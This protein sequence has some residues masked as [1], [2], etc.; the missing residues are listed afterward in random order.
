MNLEKAIEK[1]NKN[2]LLAVDVPDLEPCVFCGGKARLIVS[3]PRYGLCGAWVRCRSCGACGPVASICAT[4]IVPKK[5]F[6][7]PLLPESLARGMTAAQDAWNSRTVE[8]SR[9]GNMK[10]TTELPA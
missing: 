6:R 7:T 2:H 9:M 1:L 5:A 4:I 3:H 8:H 10:I